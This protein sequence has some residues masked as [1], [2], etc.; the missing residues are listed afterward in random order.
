MMRH[1]TSNIQASYAF[2][3]NGNPLLL[4]DMD[5]TLIIPRSDSDRKVTIHSPSFQS[6]QQ[7]RS[8]AHSYGVP[9]IELLNLDRM[10]H[11][12]NRARSYGEANC[13]SEERMANLMAELNIPFSRQEE[14]EHFSSVLIPGTIEALEV[15]QKGTNILGMVTSASRAGYERISHSVEFG[16]FW[17]YFEHSITRDDCGYIKPN[18]E[19]IN[20]ILRQFKRSDFIYIG[21]S[22]HDAEAAK[23]AGGRFILLNTKQ[24]DEKM[25]QRMNPDGIVDRLNELPDVIYN[26]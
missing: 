15:L 26:Y 5:G 16:C 25:L 2:P 11:I 20:R 9:S 22:D 24:Y 10:A 4:F 13:F 6:R 1:T 17:K 12:W 3:V 19:P 7:M 21:D 23:T 14:L 8:I 18:P